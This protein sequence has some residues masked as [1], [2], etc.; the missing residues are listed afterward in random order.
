MPNATTD[1]IVAGACTQAQSAVA[2]DPWPCA[3][4]ASCM[5]EL[6]GMCMPVQ[7]SVCAQA[8]LTSAS[9]AHNAHASKWRERRIAWSERRDMRR[10]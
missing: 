9:H 5:P 1:G 7:Q 8:M 3:C 4:A 6:S 10:G 2:A